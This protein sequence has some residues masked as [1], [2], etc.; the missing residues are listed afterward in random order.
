M[1]IPK[2]KW[3]LQKVVDRVQSFSSTDEYPQGWVEEK[4]ACGHVYLDNIAKHSELHRSGVKRRRCAKCAK[5][6]E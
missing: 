3:P 5:K 4:L 1:I 2:R 6:M